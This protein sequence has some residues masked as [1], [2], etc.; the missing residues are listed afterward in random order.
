MP[1]LIATCA[2]ASAASAADAPV[3]TKPSPRHEYTNV[4]LISLQCLRPDHLG[5]YGYQRD[6]SPNIDRLAKGSVLFENAISQANLTPVAQMSV[7][8]SQYPRVNGMVSFEVAKEG[9]SRRTLPEIL[10]Y[11]GYTTAA[12]VSSP[13]F[14]MRFD[15][16]S[17]DIIDPG[18]VFSRSFDYFGRTLRGRGA[19]V[20][21][22]PTESLEWLRQNKE[23]KFFLW[24][25]SGLLH[26]PYGASVPPQLKTMYD[27]PGYTP[28]WQRL[29]GH[30]AAGEADADP[31]YDVFSRVF[32]NDYHAGFAPVYHLGADDVRYVNA[33]YD[34]GV[35]YTDQLIGALM[36]Q[37]DAL[38]LTE[39]TLVVLQSIHGDDLGEKGA[40]FHYDVTDAVVKNA[41][42]VRFPGAEFGGKRVPEQV[43]GI[44]LM[45][46]ILN[47]LDI[48]VN[49][50]AQ[51]QSVLPL[52][53]GDRSAWQEEY[54]FIDRLPWWEYT[55]SKWYFEH[56][57][58]QGGNFSPAEEARLPAYSKLLRTSFDA[59][60]YPP[61][62][63]A[64]RTNDWKLVVRKNRELLEQVSWQGF[65]T[66]RKP[67]VAEME[68]YDLKRDP[69]ERTNV[70]GKHPEVVQRLKKRLMEWD[71]GMERRK[72][73]YSRDE[74]RWIIPYP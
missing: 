19:S 34:A 4:I 74:K 15:T 11:Y 48:P 31:A 71:A 52:L 67:Q 37:L 8:T 42:I 21:Q 73:K 26:M 5:A 53:R 62:D 39:K 22:L 54:A 10:K 44:D 33:R 68:L 17:G 18:D 6:T 61:G 66:G 25:A 2:F 43:S 49:H 28:F 63:I 35:H 27:P 29:P 20:R 58:D 16:E 47:Y 46:T 50:E 3:A 12:T 9:V 14:F 1:G 70:A 24:I 55:L 38:N 32:D 56:Q 45:P 60:G 30:P 57:R 69:Q 40:Y 36:K 41:L 23:K 13:E 65:I 59:L 64:V 72:A 51:G 7:L